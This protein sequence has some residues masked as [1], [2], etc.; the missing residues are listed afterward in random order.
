MISFIMYDVKI[1]ILPFKESNTHVLPMFD[2]V[3]ILS[4]HFL[5]MILNID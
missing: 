5:F 1:V 4:I 2:F 3:K